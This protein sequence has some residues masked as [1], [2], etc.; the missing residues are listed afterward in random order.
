MSPIILSKNSIEPFINMGCDVLVAAR[1]QLLKLPKD[2]EVV[3][4]MQTETFS[5]QKLDGEPVETPKVKAVRSR[6]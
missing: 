2:T 6:R 1:K 4:D 5:F 3:Y